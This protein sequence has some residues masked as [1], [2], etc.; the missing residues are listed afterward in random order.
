[1]RR[2]VLPSRGCRRVEVVVVSYNSR[3]HLRACVEPLARLDDVRVIVTDNASNDESLASIDDLPVHAIALTPNGG[4]AH[5]CN[6]GWRA[7]DGEYVFFLNPDAHIARESIDV[8][9]RVP[10]ESPNVGGVAPLIGHDDGSLDFSQWRYPRLRS[11]YA[12]ALSSC[13]GS[14]RRPSGPTSSF[15]GRG[16]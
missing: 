1:M 15:R 10:E 3:D 16:V 9:V 6:A 4:F 8:L 7:S 14:F 12:Q 5:G 13:T 2:A 11:T